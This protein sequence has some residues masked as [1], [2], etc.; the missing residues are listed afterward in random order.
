MNCHDP[1]NAALLVLAI[2][3]TALLLVGLLD[4]WRNVWRRSKFGPSVNTGKS[5]D[6][7]T[8]FPR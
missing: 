2:E 1:Y 3:G 6:P 7:T 5:P 8:R 4:L